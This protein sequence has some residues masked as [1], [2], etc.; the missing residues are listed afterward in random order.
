MPVRIKRPELKPREKS[1][2]VSTLVC[3]VVSFLFTVELFTM[4]NR[5]VDTGSKV[6][7]CG[8]F[9]GYLLFFAMCIVC[10][11]KGAMAYKYEDSMSALGKSLIYSVLAVIC[12]I[13]LRFALSI[14]FSAFG[15]DKITE[16]IIGTDQKSFV[17]AQYTPWMA[18][19][20]GLL[21]A[22]VIGIF[23]TLKL[24]KNQKR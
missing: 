10:L 7:T 15:A 6:M 16:K 14:L 3:M 13:N 20:A 12:L 4:L 22:D 5:I 9:A 21:L 1:F 24:V 2:C 19:L 17:Q 8:V 11:C 23:S 18:M